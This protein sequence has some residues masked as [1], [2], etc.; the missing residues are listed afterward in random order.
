V[1]RTLN[2][3]WRALTDLGADYEELRNR[4]G[5]VPVERDFLRV[6]GADAIAYLQGQCSQDLAE[7]TVGH[8]ADAL[9][10]EPQ[11]KLDAL[12]RITRTEEDSL[13]LDLAGGYGKA[14]K[15]RLERFKLRVK[16]EIELMP[17]RCVSVRGPLTSSVTSPGS[18]TGAELSV[19]YS[20]N[21][22]E[23]VDL[24]GTDP[25]VP[26][27]ARLCSPEALEALRIEAGIPAM[28]FE[29][30][31]RTIPAEAGL[32]ERCVSFTKGCYT[33]QELVAR[34]E[35]R[36]NRVAR[37]LRGVVFDRSIPGEVVPRVVGSDVIVG[38]KRVGAITSASWS[39][40]LRSVAALGYLHRDVVVPSRVEVSAATD[41]GLDAETPNQSSEQEVRQA[42]DLGA[43]ARDLPLVR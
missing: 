29:L 16:A 10:L 18:V 4:V 27:A 33:G 24:F 3:D 9:V 7:L 30:D 22:V 25:Q 11:G 6:F 41:N 35:A 34:L 5:A 43:E 8:S 2:A 20:W 39:P 40:A 12:V 32:L 14:L 21:G 13:L 28:G 37:R 42:T 17:W 38:E 1:Y 26:P 23:G 15:E 31:E 19:T 36:G